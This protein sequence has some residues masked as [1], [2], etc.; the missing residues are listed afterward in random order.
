MPPVSEALLNG[1][2]S[3]LRLKTVSQFNPLCQLEAGGTILRPGGTRIQK[4]YGVAWRRKGHTKAGGASRIAIE[5]LSLCKRRALLK[6]SG[7]GRHR[8]FIRLA[9]SSEGHLPTLICIHLSAMTNVNQQ[10]FYHSKRGW[11]IALR[12]SFYSYLYRG[13]SRRRLNSKMLIF[14]DS[15]QEPP[16]D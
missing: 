8:A 14:M 15:G 12:W 16:G 2:R 3:G 10:R 5:F 13:R 4:H 9:R 11:T 6:P 1:G 7:A